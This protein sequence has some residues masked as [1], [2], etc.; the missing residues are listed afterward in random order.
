MDPGVAAAA[1]LAPGLALGDCDPSQ[2]SWGTDLSLSF[3]FFFYDCTALPHGGAFFTH[4]EAQLSG[5]TF[6]HVMRL[7]W[8]PLR[9]KAPN[10]VRPVAEAWLCLVCVLPMAGHLWPLTLHLALGGRGQLPVPWRTDSGQR[11]GHPS[12]TSI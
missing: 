5:G 12:G 10:K 9:W 7:S 1:A 3:F 8:E 4:C 2:A 11:E 6:A